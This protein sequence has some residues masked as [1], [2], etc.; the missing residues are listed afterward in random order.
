MNCNLKTFS[1]N[2]YLFC[3]NSIENRLEDNSFVKLSIPKWIKYTTPSPH[4]PYV[5]VHE[6][7]CDFMFFFSPVS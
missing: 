3:S 2:V 5:H 7:V 4:P 1:M 6:E